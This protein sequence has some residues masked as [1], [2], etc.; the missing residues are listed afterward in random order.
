M[1]YQCAQS[2]ALLNGVDATRQFFAPSF[3]VGGTKERLLVAHVD[4][5]ARCIDISE[6]E[7][8][9][10]SV[11]LPVRSIIADALRMGSSGLILAHNHPSG[12]STPSRADCIATRRL[13]L[14][15]E[16]I[17]V[18]LVDH[19]I[20]GGGRDCRSMRRMGLL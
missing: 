13:A 18:S 6:H 8:T 1:K 5:H 15:C 12:N 16:A 20:F 3:P 4:D 14:A 7:G 17:D 11:D 10:A 2:P 9:A 19:L